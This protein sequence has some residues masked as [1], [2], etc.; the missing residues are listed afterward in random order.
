VIDGNRIRLESRLHPHPVSRMDP[1][2]I[3]PAAMIALVAFAIYRRV[4]RNIG[5]QRVRPK[6]MWFRV[7]ILG[8]IGAL[9]LIASLRNAELGGAMIA[10]LAGGV[11]LAWLGLRHT[12][13]ETTPQG[14][15][16]TPHTTIGLAVSALLLGRLAYRFLVLYPAM[17]AAAQVN[18]SPFATYQKSPLT[19]AIF[20]VLVGYFVAYYLGVLNKRHAPTALQTPNGE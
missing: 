14:N 16:Y 8:V 13:F 6:R 9:V 17:H 7:G 10:G 5:R 2:L 20:G 12:K 3:A 1:K 19:L 18:A 4:R 11:A 15:F